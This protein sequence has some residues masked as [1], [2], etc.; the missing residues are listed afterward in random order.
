M[1]SFF[2]LFLGIVFAIVALRRLK[3]KRELP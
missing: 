2:A 3:P 1:V